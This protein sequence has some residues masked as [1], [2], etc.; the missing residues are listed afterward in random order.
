LIKKSIKIAVFVL[1]ICVFACGMV[2]LAGQKMESIT[3]SEPLPQPRVVEVP[4]VAFLGVNMTSESCQRNWWHAQIEAEHRGWD[5]VGIVD[6]AETPEQ[7]DALENA[8]NQDVDAIIIMYLTMEPL[9]DLIL[10]AREKGIG[11]YCID[12]EIRDGVVINPTQPNG[13]VGAKMTYY[14]LDRT[15][16]KGNVLIL[17]ITTHILRRRTYAARGLLANDWP[18]LEVVGYEDM[19]IPGW[20]KAAFDITQNYLTRYGEDLSWIFAGWDTPGIFA[21]RAVEE[22]GLTRDDVFITGIDGGTQAYAEIRKGS[23]FIA[24]M[25]QPFEQYTHL[26]FEAIKQI[27]VD[28]IGIG[29]PGS[30]VPPSTVLY[31]DPVLTTPENL[32]P[33]GADIHEVFASTYYDPSKTDAWYTWGETY[34]VQ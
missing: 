28:G 3:A 14:G 4:K 33:V 1:L 16:G 8:I 25:S 31:V 34:K 30:M 11:V 15:R 26:V 2:A 19:P 17:S 10:K 18:A 12:T 7:R 20:E 29:E 21:A 23:P 13:V 24:T 6:L 5:M 22:A 32:P 9:R 27:Q